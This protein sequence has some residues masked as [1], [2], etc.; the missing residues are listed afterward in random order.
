MI[1]N[2]KGKDTFKNASVGLAMV[3]RTL[4]RRRRCVNVPQQD[5]VLLF[6]ISA[7]ND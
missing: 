7:R 4:R 2:K 1:Q 3:K 5:W 6:H